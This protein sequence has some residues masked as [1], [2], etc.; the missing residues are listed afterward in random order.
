MLAW[1]AAYSVAG[2]LTGTFNENEPTDS[3]YAGQDTHLLTD[4]EAGGDSLMPSGRGNSAYRDGK[5]GID[6]K[7]AEKRA[8]RQ[9]K[10]QQKN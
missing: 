6:Q 5:R 1:F 10:R 4:A 7:Y 9:A 2:S 3:K 8:A